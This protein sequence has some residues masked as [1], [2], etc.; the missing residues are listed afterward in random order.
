VLVKSKVKS[1]F[2]CENCGNESPQWEGKCSFCGKWNTLV[3]FL[4]DSG[5]PSNARNWFG[6][7]SLPAKKLSEVSLQELPRFLLTSLEFNRVLGGGIVP[8]TVVLLS[9]EPGIGKS[10]LLLQTAAD[11]AA[12][13]GSSLY[14]TGEESMAQ[15]KMRAD[16]LGIDVDNLLLLQ[17]TVLAEIID[18]LDRI[19]PS[20]AVVDS[21][22]TIYDDSSSATP[23]SVTQVRDCTRVLIQ[24]AKTSGVPIILTGHVTKGGDIAGPRLLEHMVDVVLYMEGES[25]SSWRLLRAEKNRFGSSNEVGVF[26]MSDSGLVD[27]SD[28]SKALLSERKEGTLGSIVVPTLEGSRPILVE[29]QALTSQ[30]TLPSPRRVATGIEFN[31]LLL[32]C[33]VLSRRAGISLA[34]QDIVVNVTGG[35]RL[36]E[37]AVDIGIA[38]A[39]VSSLK[40]IPVKPNIA[41]F[42][43]IGLNGEIRGVPHFARRIEEASR[44]NLQECL[45]PASPKI[46]RDHLRGF[47]TTTIETITQAMQLS[48]SK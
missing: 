3:E 29:V 10:T 8:G 32:I 25:I 30:S 41:A 37:P 13:N 17:T 31:R 24:W 19:K 21:I 36:S 48:F 46:E 1:R 39:I 26:E 33:A 22:Q 6:R 47:K 38:L 5:N 4:Q 20:L 12:S 11:V 34:N 16:R 45:I 44:L 43:E 2:L 42:G 7:L 35:L 28:P 14:V 9:G 15:V 23:G 40:N 27:I 18:H